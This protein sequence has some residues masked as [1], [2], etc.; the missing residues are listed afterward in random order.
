[1]TNKPMRAALPFAGLGQLF[2]LRNA[3]GMA[4]TISE[5]GASIVS[6]MAPDRYGRL[7][8]V[9][10]GCSDAR[11]QAEPGACWQAFA[12][13]STL[14]LRLL[15][16]VG[17][18]I[19]MHYRLDDAGALT[20]EVEARVS[21]AT[22]MHLIEHPYFNL[23]GGAA[24]VGD[25]MLRIDADYV[26]RAD[27][28]VTRVGATAFDFRLAAAVGSRLCWPDAQLEAAGGFDHYYCVG[29]NRSGALREVAAVF[30]PTTGRQLKVSTTGAGIH[31][32][33]GRSLDGFC[34]EAHAHRAM[35]GLLMPGQ[36]YRQATVYK[37]SL[38]P[39]T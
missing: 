39:G 18:E 23:N 29:Q 27:A 32:Y 2:T 8:D 37:L 6:W 5:R 12:A 9:V 31:F 14:S 28:Q 1:M 19:V 11:S 4:V 10:M 34:L 38:H 35:G 21:V 20:I 16:A 25:H 3:R 7:A 15:P 26:V 33:C 36:V 30:D 22:S 24:D 17:Q 13:Q